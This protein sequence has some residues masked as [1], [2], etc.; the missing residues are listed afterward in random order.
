MKKNLK[1]GFAFSAVIFIMLSFIIN[2][3]PVNAKAPVVVIQPGH[4]I[5]Y[6]SGAVNS[7]T[8][9]QE[10]VINAQISGRVAT[11]LKSLGYEVYLTT[12]VD[13]CSVPALLS[14]A[15]A[16]SLSK[17]ANAI[18][19]KNPDL[20]ISIHSNSGGSTAT[21]YEFYWSSYRTFD[22]EGIYE[23][24]GLWPGGDMTYRDTS[25]CLAA[26]QSKQLATIL[27]NNFKGIGIPH[28]NTVERDDYVQARTTCLQF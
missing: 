6:D 22:Q 27:E 23:V 3:Y 4:S 5:G 14:N 13:G 15:D 1:S 24:P 19:S 25:P 16:N 2:G 12:K 7:S 8:G 9:I 11:K 26:Q 28:R 20:S 18:N 17:V 10:A 21:G